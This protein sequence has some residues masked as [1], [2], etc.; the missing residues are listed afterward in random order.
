MQ[1]TRPFLKWAGNKFR[2]L[3]PIQTHLPDGHRLVE[4]FAGS[5]AIFLNTDYDKYWLNDVNP[6]LINL[7]RILKKHQAAFITH[8]ESW[9]TKRNNQ[10]KAYYRL[11]ERFNTETDPIDRAALFVYLNRH[12]YNGLCRYNLSGI[13]N[14]PF[15]RYKEPAV[16][17]ENMLAF[18]KKLKSA[19]LTC[20]SYEKV[21]AQCARGD[22]LY[23]D[24][25]YAPL[26]PSSNF[27]QY[28]SKG[29]NLADQEALASLAE[30]ARVPVLISNHDLALTRKLYQEAQLVKFKVPRSINCKGHGRQAVR[31]LL[32]VFD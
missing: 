25:P 1:K 21:F 27:T 26:S 19:K 6:D 10:E 20:W 32:A 14:V 18:A 3:P 13:F 22:V 30:K 15:G 2:I 24:P 31:E 11:R 5:G 8:C 29:F 9:F 17:R 16:P 4:P 28:H 7:F 23:C 12:G